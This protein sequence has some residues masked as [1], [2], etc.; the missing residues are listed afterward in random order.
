ME[1]DEPEGVLLEQ[2]SSMQTI[3]RDDLVQ[4]MIRLVGENINSAAAKFYLEMNQW[5]VQS[6]VGAYFDL[7]LANSTLPGMVFVRDVTVGEGESVPPN[8]RF[9]KTWRVQNPGPDAWP[10][11]CVLRYV[12]GAVLSR[13]ERVIAGPLDPYL[14]TDIS[15]DMTSP[16]QPG[17]Y[18]SKWRM[19]TATGSFFGDVIWVIISVEVAGTLSITQQ[20]DSLDQLGSR[21]A[22]HSVNRN[23]FGTPQQQVD[24]QFDQVGPHAADSVNRNPFLSNQHQGPFQ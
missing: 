20:F 8:T 12:N 24:T 22:N 5:N 15:I 7:E 13:T 11:G 1:V 23:P 2:F 21:P 3:D 9:V 4:Q 14:S 6:A 18:Q 19:S 17:L 10:P 16:A